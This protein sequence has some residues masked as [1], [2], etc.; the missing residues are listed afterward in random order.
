VLRVGKASDD[1]VMVGEMCR[2]GGPDGRDE[3]AQGVAYP[4]AGVGE[5][6]GHEGGL[7]ALAICE[8]VGTQDAGEE[9]AF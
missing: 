1:C 4:Q 2:S 6:A 5:V 8:H 3:A 7:N 9:A